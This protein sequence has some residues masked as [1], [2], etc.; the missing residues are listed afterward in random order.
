MAEAKS[1]AKDSVIYGGTTIIMKFISW[2]MTPLFTYSMLKSDFGM[3][4][5]VYAFSALI[6]VVLTFGLETGFFWFVN[7]NSEQR[8][9]SVYSTALLMVTGLIGLFLLLF[10]TFLPQIRH[11][12]FDASIPQLYLR[13]MFIIA[14]LDSFIALPFAFLRYEKKPLRF[15]F[16][17]ILQVVLYALLCLFFLY[18]CPKINKSRPEL[19]G[20]FWRDGFSVGYILI[21][22]LIATGIQAICLLAQMRRFKLKFDTALARQMFSYCYPLMLMGLAGMSNQVV[23]KLVFP[24]VYPDKANAFAQL[25]VYSACFKIGIIMI[26]FTQ[27]FRYAFD[28]FMFEKGKER[29]AKESYSL[30]MKYFTALGFVVFLVVMFYID[31]FKHFVA[32]AYWVALPIVPVVLIGELF[33]AVYYNLSVWYKLTKQTWWGTLFSIVGFVIIVILNIVF[34]PHYGYMACAWASFAGNLVIMLLSYFIGQT[35]YPVRYDLKT[36]GL[37]ALLASTLYSVSLILP[38]SNIYV[39][40]AVNTVLLII[41]LTVLIKRDFKGSFKFI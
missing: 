7:Q 12:M 20:W 2:L 27:A 13:L 18:V 8:R 28:P 24:A 4:T 40:M 5:N 17:K 34:I 30:V 29:D 6:I 37:Y 1:L 39:K 15:G 14:A 3:M 25:G 26:M 36:I 10:Q 21:S 38:A 23:D 31:I 19:I 41:Y 9:D 33:F 32:P 35:K 16:Y 11:L 22:N